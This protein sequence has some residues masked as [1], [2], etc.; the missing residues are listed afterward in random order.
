MRLNVPQDI[1]SEFK[2]CIDVSNRPLLVPLLKL[3]E[4]IS[5]I[6]IRPVQQK[7]KVYKVRRSL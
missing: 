2:G 1:K 4:I 6:E 5:N 7:S 3:F